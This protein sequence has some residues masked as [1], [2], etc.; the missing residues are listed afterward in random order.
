MRRKRGLA[1]RH[2]VVIFLTLSVTLLLFAASSVGTTERIY[3][4]AQ[5]TATPVSHVV[6][7]MMENHS[8]DN[9]F[10]AYPSANRTANNSTTLSQIIAPN[11]LLNAPSPEVSQVPAGEYSTRNP[12]EGYGVYHSDW[13]GGKMDGFAKNSGSLSMTHFTSSQLSLE[14][15]WAEEYGL[16]DNYF[17]SFL[18]ETDPN[19][20][21]SLAGFSSVTA[22]YGPPP[23]ISVNDSILAQLSNAGVPW[24][25]YIE[26]PSQS[27]FPLNYF[28]GI[29]TYSANIGSWNEFFSSLS[30]GSLPSVSWVMPVGGG[31]ESVSQHPPENVTQ[32]EVWLERI[33]NSVMESKYW[34]SSAIFVTYDE[35]GGYYDHVA[36]PVID[37]T[38]LGFRVPLLVI[39]PFSKEGYVSH[40]LL[41]HDSL[42]SF[43]EYNWGLPALNQF[44]GDSNVPLDFFDFGSSR[45]P[46]I[47]SASTTFPQPLQMRSS[48][49]SYAREGSSDITL[50]H[51]TLDSTTVNENNN[52]QGIPSLA[53]EIFVASFAVFAFGVVLGGRKK[54]KKSR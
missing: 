29:E 4:D 23:Y 35:G 20:L 11:N 12:V 8:F 51:T 47:F 38:Q 52:V 19:R 49:L 9:I 24:R 37:G 16:G 44:V 15:N 26:E 30:S 40:T 18:G 21:F 48:Q 14:W 46:L 43:I 2:K 3:A 6:I 13:D 25:Y 32:G 42:L 28:S 41:N 36:P 33:V 31:A 17:A 53:I 45:L 5:N 54:K 22:D 10:G 7:V 27:L 34:D 50:N 1:G 39:S